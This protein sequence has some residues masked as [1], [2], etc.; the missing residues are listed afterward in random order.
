MA[1]EDYETGSAKQNPE[2]G[3]VAVRTI[4]PDLPAFADRQW[5]VMT[6][7]NGGHYNSYDGIADWSDITPVR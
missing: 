3:A 2:T 7:D 5:A 1:A 4:F 6:V